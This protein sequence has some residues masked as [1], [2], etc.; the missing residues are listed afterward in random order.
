MP[1]G[2]HGGGGGGGGGMKCLGLAG[3]TLHPSSKNHSVAVAL[4][5]LGTAGGVGGIHGCSP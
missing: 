5:L 4:A 1:G 2:G 3:N